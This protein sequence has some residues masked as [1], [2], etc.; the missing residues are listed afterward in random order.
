MRIIYINIVEFTMA[1]WSAILEPK[2]QLIYET[3]SLSFDLCDSW[4]SAM[5]AA[6]SGDF[7]LM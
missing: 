7:T 5:S 4:L 2:I 3:A 6:Y 1:I